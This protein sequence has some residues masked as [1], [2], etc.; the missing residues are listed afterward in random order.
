MA[1][2]NCHLP[3]RLAEDDGSLFPEAIIP[4]LRDHLGALC[5]ARQSDG[6]VFI[7]PSGVTPRRTNFNRIWQWSHGQ[8][9]CRGSA[10]FTTFVTAAILSPLRR[11][12]VFAS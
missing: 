9:R 1:G 8:G 5:G 10:T 2:L 7:G 4:D 12:Q 11:E 3:R 6:R